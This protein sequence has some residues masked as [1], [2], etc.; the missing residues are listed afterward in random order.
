MYVKVVLNVGLGNG[1]WPLFS[2]CFNT[3]IKLKA[4][5]ST[6]YPNQ[7]SPT[8]GKVGQSV[9]RTRGREEPSR[10]ISVSLRFIPERPD[11]D[12]SSPAGRGGGEMTG[13]IWAVSL[14]LP[15][16]QSVTGQ[17]WIFHLQWKNVSLDY[18]VCC[19][20]STQC[21]PDIEICWISLEQICIIVGLIWTADLRCLPMRQR[22]PLSALLCDD[23]SY[24][25]ILVP[26]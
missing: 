10:T 3:E 7:L 4:K 24:F 6:R 12:S 8:E 16:G 21:A 11:S 26:T 19:N 20:Y 15:A 13:D 22:C 1:G 14:R 18:T 9:A 17:N 23:W 2:S 25:L 5:S